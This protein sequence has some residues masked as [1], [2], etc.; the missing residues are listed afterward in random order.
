MPSQTVLPRWHGFNL[1]NFYTPRSDQ[2]FNEE[3]FRWIADWGFNF[4]R[5]PMDYHLWTPDPF[6]DKIDEAVLERLDRAIILA[7]RYNLHISLNLHRAPGYCINPGVKEPFNLWKEDVALEAFCF[8]WQ[9][10]SRRYSGIAPD[11]LSFDLVNEPPQPS[12]EVMTRGD[13]ERVVRK[14]VTAIREISPDRL[15]MI[16]GVGVGNEPCPELADLH[17]VQSCRAYI[18]MGI[19]HYQARWAG[20]EKYPKPVWPGALHDDGRLWDRQLLEEHYE[21]WGELAR[22]G[23]GV[24]C[25]EGG[26]FNK[27]PYQVF[28]AW[29]QDV[30]E[31]LTSHN[32]GY[33]LWE[34]SGN[35]G[36]L[37]SNRIDVAYQNWYGHQ[38][39]QKLLELLQRF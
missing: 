7:E 36:I 26:C 33:S 28:L 6:A 20:G 24:H 27:T 22:K 25:G 34:F 17:V 21:K 11:R 9:M 5:V 38:L 13:Y 39:D 35:F 23:V 29:F 18:P 3:Y 10:F 19:S 14:S 37:D 2:Q 12:P 16:E 1:L 4:I 32:I 30:L 8:Q 31:I 15:I